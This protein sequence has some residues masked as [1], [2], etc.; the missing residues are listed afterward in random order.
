MCSPCLSVDRKRKKSRGAAN[1]Q[2]ELK[3]LQFNAGANVSI[4]ELRDKLHKKLA[5]LQAKRGGGGKIGGVSRH[6]KDKKKDKK[7][8]K[9]S[10]QSNRP[11]KLDAQSARPATKDAAQ[12]A[13]ASTN[14]VFSKF[15]FSD[16]E[17]EKR[18][19]GEKKKNLKHLLQKA[20]MPSGLLC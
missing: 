14:I 19:H 11:D 12:S 2:V 3:P 16:A 9:K 1:G 6:E 8:K 15:D 17:A 4:G 7:D 5:E 20:V 18:A 13:N 10:S